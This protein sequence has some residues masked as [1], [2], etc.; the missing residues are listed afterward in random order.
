[1][2]I[3]SDIQAIAYHPVIDV[4]LAPRQLKEV[5]QTPTPFKT[6]L[7]LGS[8]QHCLAAVI[9]ISVFSTLFFS[10]NKNIASYQTVF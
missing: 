2:Y 3:S 4:Q 5:Q 6:L 8:V 1:M 10:G 9:N 7:G